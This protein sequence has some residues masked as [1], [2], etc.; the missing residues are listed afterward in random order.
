MVLLQLIKKG[1]GDQTWCW[2]TRKASP[3]WRISE[4]QLVHHRGLQALWLS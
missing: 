2:H 3:C 1:D 4:G